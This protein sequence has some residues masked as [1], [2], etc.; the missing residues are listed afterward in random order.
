MGRGVD[1]AGYIAQLRCRIRFRW[2]RIQPVQAPSLRRSCGLLDWLICRSSVQL[3]QDGHMRVPVT[4]DGRTPTPSSTPERLFRRSACKAR[5]VC[6]TLTTTSPDV[7]K[8]G[9]LIGLQAG[10]GGL[11]ISVQD[12]DHGR[13]DLS[14]IPDKCDGR[15]N[16][17]SSN[18]ATILLGMDMLPRLHLYIA[19]R[20]QKLYVTA[21]DAPEI[22]GIK[23]P[24]FP[25]AFFV[26]LR[27]M[28]ARQFSSEAE[29]A[30]AGGKFLDRSL[31]KPE[32]THAAHFAVSLWLIR[33]RPALDLD[34]TLPGLI[35]AF[36]EAS[37]TPNTDSGG[38]HETITRA[39]RPP[40]GRGWP[41]PAP[42][43]AQSSG[44]VAGLAI[45]PIRL[46][47]GILEPRAAFFRG[48]PAVMACPRSEGA[49]LCVAASVCGDG[50]ALTRNAHSHCRG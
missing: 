33:H 42:S 9:K 46:A 29:I 50:S 21:V 20:E 30:R 49:S 37:G 6:S 45:G 36:N 41:Q 40:S 15:R 17:L 38:Y 1:R 35:R 16:F 2:R 25:P 4:L 14:P 13:R 31:P 43:P 47:A 19:Y 3:T 23:R 8:A 39:S 12:P 48:G 11:R 5:G 34:E 32:W 10:G 27:R 24:A 26:I 7:K 18:D 28:K 22:A 44:R